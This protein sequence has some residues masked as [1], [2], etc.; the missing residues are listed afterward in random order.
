MKTS[1]HDPLQILL[2]FVMPEGLKKMDHPV[3]EFACVYTLHHRKN[4]NLVMHI[5]SIWYLT[6]N[7]YICTRNDDFI[8]D[9]NL[10]TIKHY[11]IHGITTEFTTWQR[12]R[13]LQ[14]N[15]SKSML[16]VCLSLLVVNVPLFS[17][18]V[19]LVAFGMSSV[20]RFLTV[21]LMKSR[22]YCL[23]EW[24]FRIFCT[25]FCLSLAV[26]ETQTVFQIWNC[27][28]L[29]ASR[30]S[31]TPINALL[32]CLKCSSTMSFKQKSTS[33]ESSIYTYNQL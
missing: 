29:S 17:I 33:S 15:I 5:I 13:F 28:W 20:T 9:I 16:L 19:V 31:S 8:K 18:I 4:H 2:W 11:V 3:L 23:N 27:L 10:L 24:S 26:C 1:F 32:K 25:G 6:M 14:Y 7:K 22:M 21:P 30:N 12:L